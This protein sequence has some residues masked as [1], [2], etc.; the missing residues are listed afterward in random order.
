MPGFLHEY[1]QYIEVLFSQ[2]SHN[3]TYEL[4]SEEL[5]FFFNR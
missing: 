4:G 1:T 5:L 3:K 2:P